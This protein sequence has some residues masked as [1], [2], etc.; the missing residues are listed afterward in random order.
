MENLLA[1]LMEILL[2]FTLPILLFS[3]WQVTSYQ[4]YAT[5][6]INLLNIIFS[7]FLTYFVEATSGEIEYGKRPSIKTTFGQSGA[8][9]KCIRALISCSLIIV[10]GQS[11]KVFMVIIFCMLVV[12][13]Y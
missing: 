8:G 7:L 13:L 11:S 9:I 1:K 12:T 4:S 10:D 6:I 3:A 2:I 5:V